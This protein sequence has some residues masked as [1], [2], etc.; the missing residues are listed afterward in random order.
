MT[1]TSI[2]PMS[3]TGPDPEPFHAVNPYSGEKLG[4]YPYLEVAQID[5]IIDRAHAG[6]EQ[7]RVT[8]VHERARMV[9]RAADLV[10]ERAD[11]LARSIC[12]EMGKLIDEAHWEISV[13]A[14]ILRYY[15]ENGPRFL[16]PNRLDIDEQGDAWV[17]YEP[18][19]VLLGIEPWNFPLYQVVRLA[20]PNLVA[21]NTILLKHTSA[22]PGTALM[23][24]KVFAD[25]GAGEGVYTNVFLRTA[26]VERVIAH[27]A[28]QGVALTGSDAAGAAVAEQAGRHVKKC[29]LELGGN[30]PFIVLD[31]PDLESTIDMAMQGRM[32]N[33]GQSCVASKRFFVPDPVH[34]RFVQALADRMA[35]LTPGDPADPGTTLGPLSSED[36]A[37]ELLEQVQD[38]LDKGAQAVTGGGRPADRGPGDAGAFVEPTVLTGVTPEMRAFSEELFGP[39]AIVHRVSDVDEAVRMANDSPYGLG[40]TIVG[41]DTDAAKD[42]ARRIESGMVWI[43][44]PT[45]TQAD[46]PFGGV[47]HSGFGRELSQAGMYEFVNRK[48]IR[49]VPA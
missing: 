17:H 8:D 48:L 43:N 12:A 13:S 18:L 23:I 16:E 11:E 4:E 32:F 33:T 38:A 42:V 45:M 47:K 36:A 7:W 3:A 10:H 39:V 26:D 41:A 6:F 49:T 34:D 5:E 15:S 14:D 19:G 1:S 2:Q 25:A 20:A 37:Q 29:L 40:A 35:D 31:S 22:C 27:P 9:G 46:L 30:D 28:V 44:T 21:G 24:E